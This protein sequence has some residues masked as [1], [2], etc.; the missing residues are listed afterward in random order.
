MLKEV[1]DGKFSI[2]LICPILGRGPRRLIL[3]FNGL[4]DFSA[5]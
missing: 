2:R 1:K 3:A 4:E 5:T